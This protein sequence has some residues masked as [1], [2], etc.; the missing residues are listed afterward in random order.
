M[1]EDNKVKK[2]VTRAPKKAVKTK[3]VKTSKVDAKESKET[4]LE[5]KKPV[6][7]QSTRRIVK[8]QKE[9]IEIV[10]KSVEFSLLEVI[11]I[12]LITG[13]VVSVASGLIVYNNYDKINVTNTINP[14][15]L[16]EFYEN[17]NK[18]INNYVEEVDKQELLDAAISGMYNYLGDEYSMYMSKDDTDD[19]EEQLT[20]EYTGVGIEITTVV[21]DDNQYVQI[22]RVFKDSPAEAAGLKTGDIIKAVDGEEMKDANQV[23][24]TIKKGNKESYEITY[25]RDGKENTLILTRKKVLINSVSSEVYNNVGYIKID[26]F[27]ATTKT[28]LLNILDNFDKKVTSLVI[29]LRDNTGGYLDTAY[30]VSD[31]FLEKGKIVYQLKDRNGNITSY[32]A[33]DGVYRKFNKI[34][35]LINENSASASEILTLALKESAGATVVG[36][37]SYGKGTVQETGTLNSGSMVKYT[38][39]Y[40]LSPKGNSINKLGIEPDIKV[41]E[42]EKQLDEALKAAK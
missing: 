23:S 9:E 8:K 19:L 12:V 4:L 41:T 14:A 31:L 26:T 24:N 16:D 3:E 34:V 20:G 38:I 30:S 13:L 15:E 21:E 17:Y 35:V 6:K 33:Q 40:W 42:V 36:N 29:D 7:K 32:K 22:H 28:Q 10:K 25:V 2:T 18:I 11:V 37:R 1:K 39:S 5:A 27:S